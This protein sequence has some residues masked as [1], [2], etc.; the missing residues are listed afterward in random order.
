MI[1]LII[2][3]FISALIGFSLPYIIKLTIYLFRR[4]KIDNLCSQWY[5]YSFM[6][7]KNLPRI[8]EGTI[9]ISKGIYSLYKSTAYENGLL[10]KGTVS[11]ENNHI[12][13]IHKAK[14]ESRSETSCIRL[15]Y[16][17]YNMHNKLYGYWLSYDSDNYISCGT[18]LLSKTKLNQDEVISEMKIVSNN[19]E[20]LILRLFK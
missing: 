20:N 1:D 2:N 19:Y 13:V 14:I 9:T 5:S 8:F 7:D 6:M 10:Y 17:S 12:L 16:S 18:I 4:K 3:S 15:D 11:I